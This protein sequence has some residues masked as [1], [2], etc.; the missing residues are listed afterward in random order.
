MVKVSDGTVSWNAKSPSNPPPARTR[1]AAIWDLTADV[2]SHHEFDRMVVFGGE[3]AGG[4]SGQAWA[5]DNGCTAWTPL[6]NQPN[7]SIAGH[8]AIY[9]PQVIW[10]LDPE[11]YTEST[12]TWQ[13]QQAPRKQRYYP[14][15]FVLPSGN[16]FAAGSK[17]TTF[18]FK[19]VGTSPPV[20]QKLPATGVSQVA[21]G[22]AVSFRPGEIMKCGTEFD[23]AS[24]ITTKIRI[25][26]ND[27][28]VLGWQMSDTMTA[29]TLKR[30]RWIGGGERRKA[31]TFASTS[32][33][34]PDAGSAAWMRAT[35][36][37]E[38]TWR[39]GMGETTR[40]CPRHLASIS[41]A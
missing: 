14:F 12:G 40:G 23:P 30:C 34:S 1:H 2:P 21:G 16:L 36:P 8:T 27:T 6:P 32:T 11:L 4:A 5:L 15:M 20:W 41:V 29:D 31:E 10:A 17:D 9:H 19:R 18:L 3:V 24:K 25:E 26:A 33:T 28:S 37:R 7:Y 13:G 39:Y 35:A 22:S 38:R